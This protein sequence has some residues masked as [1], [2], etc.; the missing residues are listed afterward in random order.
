MNS[1]DYLHIG[2]LGAAYSFSVLFITHPLDSIKTTWQAKPSIHS[3]RAVISH[4][5]RTKGWRGFYSGFFPNALRASIKHLYRWPLIAVLT[6]FFNRTLPGIP[7]VRK[8]AMSV[9]IANMEVF[10]INPLEKGKVYFQTSENTK[11]VAQEFFST[12]KGKG[13]RA[14]YSGFRAHLLRQ[15]ISWASFLLCEDHFKRNAKTLL[16]K[17]TLNNWEL[18]LISIPIGVVNTA[19]VMPFDY[20]KTR[21]QKKNPVI[22]GIIQTAKSEFKRHGARA[23]YRGGRF[24]LIQYMFRMIISVRMMAEVE[25]LRD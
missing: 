17:E 21:Y 24:R 7:T 19:L 4:I 5:Y 22:T 13:W 15:N 3:S 16:N 18:L 25:R 20:V 23:F 1:R 2:A 8:L 9:A 14:F 11:G 12:V 6:P 10:L